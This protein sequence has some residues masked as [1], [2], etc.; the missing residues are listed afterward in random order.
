MKGPTLKPVTEV[1][2]RATEI[3]AELRHDKRPV[4]ITERGRSAAVLLDVESY[5]TML[6]QLDLLG[7][8]ARG[9]RAILENRVVSHAAA[10][11]RLGR[12]L[13]KR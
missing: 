5:E 1:K 8:I 9:E 3:I 4:L 13:P 11:R 6:R 12:W 10:R 7:G 2:R